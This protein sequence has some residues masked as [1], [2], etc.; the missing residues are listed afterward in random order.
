MWAISKKE[1]THYFGSLTGFLVICF[2]LLANSLFLFVL[3]NFNVLDFGYASLQ[4]YFDYA[5]WFL[6]LLV[7][8]I[9]MR[10]FSEELRQGS[11]ELLMSLPISPLQ[12]VLGKLMGVIM[13]L[14]IALAPT[15]L[16]GIALDQLSSTGG[17][18]WGATAGAYWGLFLLASVYAAVGIFASAITKQALV[19]LLVSIS[20]CIFLYKGFDWIAALPF[21][22]NGSGFYVQQLG[23][24]AHFE[25]MGKGVL[26]ASDLVY[27]LSLILLFVLGAVEKI[28]YRK[29]SF[30]VYLMLV[31]INIAM[32]FAPLQWDLTKDERY[33]LS[34]TSKQIIAGVQEPVKIHL[35]LGGNLPTQ[36]KKL[37]NAAT[38]ILNK[39]VQE[40][41]QA[42]E[43]QLD[44]PNQMYKDT[45]LYEAYDSLSKLGLPIERV[46]SDASKADQRIDQLII[47]GLLIIMPGKQPI[48]V[49]LRSSK[50]YFKPYNIIKDV[51]EEDLDAS[52]NAAEALLEFK[53]TQ[54]LYFLNRKTIPTIGYLIGNGEPIDLSVNDLG[55]SIRHQ[56]HLAVFD[57]KKGFP[58][59]PAIKT[60]LIVKPT[61]PFTE[62]DKFKIDQ[63]L[64]S[65]GNI[66]WA[67][68]R[69]HAEY[70]SLQKTAGAY[71]AYDRNLGLDDL[72]F[73]YGVRMNS[74]LVQD[75]NCSKLPVVVGK[76]PTGN[77]V[78][79]RIPWPYYPFLNGNN[80]H[81]IVKNIDRVLSQFPSSIDTIK[82]RGIQK[83][84]LLS[85]DTNSRLV[86]T[87]NLISLNSGKA[88]NELNSF[89][90]HQIP[91][92]VLLEGKFSSLY[93]NR[94]N[95]TWQDSLLQ[96]TGKPFQSSSS[97]VS[98]Q[99]VIADADI[100]TNSVDKTNG[101]MPMGVLPFEAYQFG[102]RDFF[103]NA[104]VYLNEPVDIL[105]A[106]NKQLVL[107]LLNREK[108]SAQK[109]A[110]QFILTLGPIIA[111]SFGQLFWLFYRKRQFAV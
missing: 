1:W 97:S 85:T 92:A 103:T 16:Y 6:L 13:I 20:I 89:T 84:I 62:L 28:Q 90:Q 8:A 110:W 96:Y 2:Y 44:L 39:I 34:N 101:P 54:A 55:Q 108:V 75:L 48:A 53:I 3:P 11:F 57:L 104:I 4:V 72:L 91:I 32:H 94:V 67:V 69:L 60:L 10:S 107:R 22:Q 83:T 29:T 79:Q 51:P 9:T 33:T 82:A 40:N 87:P 31:V 109:T 66:I 81:V 65:G 7:P 80:G 37:A 15:L 78:I 27:L 43:W 38:A 12:M 17:L 76:D 35:Y 36:Y 47:P 23:L 56:Y 106:R 52:A 21:F 41:T 46:Q 5:P 111:L 14:A 64:M 19:A 61:Q 95:P 74:N 73:K 98:K 93:H 59:A 63:Y 45:V 49:D 58:T 99:I 86:A 100:L 30:L 24:Q 68:D 77:P 25:N 70:D 50:K 105:E 26:Y 42:I 88:P 71:I 102:N 18:D